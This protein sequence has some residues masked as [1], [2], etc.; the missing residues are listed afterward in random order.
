MLVLGVYSEGK[1]FMDMMLLQ[2]RRNLAGHAI[3]GQNYVAAA[4]AAAVDLERA[5]KEKQKK[6]G[7]RKQNTGR[8][9]NKYMRLKQLKKELKVM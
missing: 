9:Q 1:H 4:A 6:R 3:A 2:R 7:R 8:H 5:V